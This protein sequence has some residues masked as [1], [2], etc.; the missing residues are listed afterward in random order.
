MLSGVNRGINQNNDIGVFRGL[1][2]ARRGMKPTGKFSESGFFTN[3]AICVRLHI[4]ELILMLCWQR[5]LKVR[6]GEVMPVSVRYAI[7]TM[8][9]L[10]LFEGVPGVFSSFQ[11]WAHA[12]GQS[13]SNQGQRTISTILGNQTIR[14][15]VADTD[16]SRREGLLGW[17][18]ITEDTGM[19]LDFGMEGEYA[20]HMQGMKFPIDAVWIDANG[21]IKIIYEDITPNSGLIYPSAF[22]CRYCLEIKSGFCKKY[23]VKIGQRVQF[24]TIPTR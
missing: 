12:E 9:L 3:R 20:I 5:E 7:M 2:P 6:A 18:R 15:V 24:G 13:T 1:H 4:H 8:C 11:T 14:T 21:A 19:L 23:G 22:P 10:V 16:D 17:D